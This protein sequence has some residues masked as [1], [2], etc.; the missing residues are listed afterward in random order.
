MLGYRSFF[1]FRDEPHAEQALHGQLF[2]WLTSKSWDAG[3]LVEGSTQRI[4]PRTSGTLVRIGGHTDGDDGGESAQ[5]T[6]FVFD[7][8][9]LGGTWTTSVTLHLEAGGASGWVWFDIDSPDSGPQPKPPRIAGDLLR[10]VTGRD[11]DHVL[12]GQARIARRTQAAEILQSI[13]DPRRRGLLFLAGTDDVLPLDK[14]TQYVRGIL[15]DTVGLASAHVLDAETTALVNSWLPATHRIAPGTVRTF[16]PDVD[17][18]DPLDGERHR[19]LGTRRIIRDEARALRSLLAHQARSLSVTAP[20]P[21]DA[22]AVDE[23]LRRRID[24]ALLDR[25]VPTDADDDTGPAPAPAQA[26]GEGTAAATVTPPVPPMSDA[27][28]PPAGNVAHPVLRVLSSVVKDVLGAVSVTESAVRTLGALA[29][30]AQRTAT[31]REDLEERLARLESERAAADDEN[32][33]LRGMLED[34][35]LERGQA[36]KDRADA[37]RH[38]RHVRTELARMGQA[39]AAW[40]EPEDDPLDNRPGSHDDLLLRF[41]DLPFV[42]FTGDAATTHDLDKHDP[43]GT[44]AGKSWDALLALNDY[45]RLVRG[46]EFHGSVHHYLMDTPGSCRGYPARSHAA[47]E[48]DSVRNSAKMRGPRTLPVPSSVDPDGSI[49]MGAHFKISR[50]RGISPRMHYYDDASGTGK[51]YVGY[52]GPH[53]PTTLTN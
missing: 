52:I 42:E 37:E 47:D 9:G 12:T 23:Q 13:E 30:R 39:E 22:V 43:L 18:D 27:P 50:F 24:E 28:P 16:R 2:R 11:G 10:S 46:G 45:C 44:W 19:I 32:V 36:D 21:R 51:I 33:L 40:S 14:W 41:D 20:L 3:K 4:S 53:L 38:L 5:S 6:R 7:E 17:V 26:D 34:E 29:R 1:R 15:H 25:A 31:A 8:D 49:F 35:Q 48:S